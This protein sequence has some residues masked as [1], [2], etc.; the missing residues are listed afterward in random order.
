MNTF[1][2][3]HSALENPISN[4]YPKNLKS[5]S[6]EQMLILCVH[7]G[8]IL[9]AVITLQNVSDPHQRKQNC[10]HTFTS[11]L[12]TLSARPRECKI[13]NLCARAFRAFV[14]L[15]V[16]G[17]TSHRCPRVFQPS[18]T[19]MSTGQSTYLGSSLG[20]KS[21][22][23]LEASVPKTSSTFLFIRANLD[24]EINDFMCSIVHMHNVTY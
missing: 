9:P 20:V 16:Y 10:L 5:S 18:C 1:L 21:P 13:E 19:S 15:L 8:H 3:C 22:K 23:C 4:H 24:K 14:S 11:H 12:M 2:L 17:K 6:D 7:R